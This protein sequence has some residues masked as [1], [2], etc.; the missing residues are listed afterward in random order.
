M[1]AAARRKACPA[2]LL[3]LPSP[4]GPA[5]QEHHS[6]VLIPW[7]LFFCR[8]HYGSPQFMFL[9]LQVPPTLPAW[10]MHLRRQLP[11]CTCLSLI[12]Q[13]SP[14]P[15]SACPLASYHRSEF[16]WTHALSV[17][18][19]SSHHCQLPYFFTFWSTLTLSPV[20]LHQWKCGFFYTMQHVRLLNC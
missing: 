13:T 20:F 14:F 7:L 19:D 8:H 15:Q 16:T 5:T 2:S 12:P 1:L 10:G 4:Q 18:R 17:T 6:T 3:T 11:M 9:R